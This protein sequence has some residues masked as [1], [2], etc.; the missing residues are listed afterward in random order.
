MKYDPQQSNQELA[1]ICESIESS[2]FERE[3]EPFRMWIDRNF[4]FHL[5][6]FDSNQ[7]NRNLQEENVGYRLGREPV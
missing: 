6:Q 7:E 1:L 3:T 2:G 5:I 4:V